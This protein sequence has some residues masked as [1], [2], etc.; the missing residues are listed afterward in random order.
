MVVLFWANIVIASAKQLL[1]IS[2]QES[3]LSNSLS[4]ASSSRTTAVTFASGIIA[5]VFVFLTLLTTKANIKHKTPQKQFKILK[6]PKT[7]PVSILLAHLIKS[8]LFERN[9]CLLTT[10]VRH[11][12]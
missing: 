7:F 12:A 6:N 1:F 8:E 2:L 11:I 5:M 4:F 3:L 10:I 9:F